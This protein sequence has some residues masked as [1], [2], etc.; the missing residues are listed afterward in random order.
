MLDAPIPPPDSASPG[1]RLLPT[2]PI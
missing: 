1:N 2:R